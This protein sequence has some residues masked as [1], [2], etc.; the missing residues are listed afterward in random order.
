MTGAPSATRADALRQHAP[1]VRQLLPNERAALDALLTCDFPGAEELRRQASTVLAD[2]E[3]LVIDL[4]VDR[5]L[6]LVEVA[7]RVP[8]GAPVT[9]DERN[10]NGLLLFVDGGR[11]SAL[12]YWW[13]SHEMPDGFPEASLIGEPEASL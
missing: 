10:A 5:A 1:V 6:P 9:D 7:S 2:G 13:T 3:G 12:E 8:V 11:L 4:I